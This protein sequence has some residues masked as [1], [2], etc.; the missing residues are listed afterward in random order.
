[1]KIQGKFDVTLNPL[2]TFAA[3]VEGLM[4]GRLSI[5]KTFHGDLSAKSRGE[6]LSAKTTVKGSAGYVAIEQVEGSLNGKT[7]SFVL[8]HFGIMNAGQSRLILEVV[9]D[10]GTRE[11]VGLSGSMEIKIES[12]QHFYVFEYHLP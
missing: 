6:M 9:P 10:S 7:G 4:L 8:Q 2:E 1:M 11:L 12:G 5:E 3:G